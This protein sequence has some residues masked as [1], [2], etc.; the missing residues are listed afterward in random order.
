[1]KHNHR[2]LNDTLL[3]GLLLL[4]AACSNTPKQEGENPNPEVISEAAIATGA[5]ASTRTY[6]F[7]DG[8]NLNP[9][10][11]WSSV[12]NNNWPESTVGFIYLP[13]GEFEPKKDQFNVAAVEE[14]LSKSGVAGR[15]FTVRLFC[16]YIAT[17]KV[18]ECPQW[19]YTDIG[20]KRIKGDKG[21]FI[22]DF[23][24]PRYVQRATLAIQALAKQ[25]DNDPR[26]HAFQLGVLGFWGEWNTSRYE[27]KG[28][29]EITD[30]TKTAILTA[31][32]SAFSKSPLMGRYPYK[33]PSLQSAG[34]G[35]HND[36]FIADPKKN[37]AFDRALDSGGQWRDGPIGGEVP[38]RNDSGDLR[39]EKK[40]LFTNRMGDAMIAKGRY[41]TMDP[42]A[43]RVEKGDGYYNDYMRL[44]RKFGYNFQIQS[45]TFSDPLSGATTMPVTVETKNIGVAPFYYPWTTQIALLNKQDQPVTTA[46]VDFKLMTAT[47]GATFSLSQQLNLKGVPL[48]DYRVAIRIIQTGADSPKA[49]PWK[50]AARNTYILFANTMP[51][52]PGS[53]ASDNALKGGWSILGNVTLK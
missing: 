16:E 13:W 17:D 14:R 9:H 38:P 49:T 4:F 37:E 51:E 35:F 1:M 45:A 5:A 47:P 15:H 8:S 53:W 30:A 26:V 40:D 19:L 50:L 52:V 39:R 10:K 48:A 6:P 44:Q 3:L 22:T 31:Y 46:T 20:V 32:K 33:E 23:N 2:L 12:R 28:S 42:G 7:N 18:S 27:P 21:T 43:Y 11:G 24:D 29:Y 34:I 25:Y 36:W 41:S